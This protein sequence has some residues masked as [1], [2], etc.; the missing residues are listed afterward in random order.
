MVAVGDG[1]VHIV[2]AWQGGLADP[3]EIERARTHPNPLRGIEELLIVF[4]SVC[5]LA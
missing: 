3:V 4:T 1:V 2:I 5:I